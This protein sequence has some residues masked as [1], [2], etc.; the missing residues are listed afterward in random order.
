MS[1]LMA[2]GSEVTNVFQL[3]GMLEN[4]ITKSMG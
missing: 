2:H 4:D 1:E 3:I